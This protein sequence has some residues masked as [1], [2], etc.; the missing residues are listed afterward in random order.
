MKKTALLTLLLNSFLSCSDKTHTSALSCFFKSEEQ[1]D[2]LLKAPLEIEDEI[3]VEDKQKLQAISNLKKINVLIEKMN[4][5]QLEQTAN[6]HTLRTEKATLTKEQLDV[7]LARH[8]KIK[9]KIFRIKKELHL[10]EICM[11]NSTET[12]YSE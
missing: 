10:L 6:F 5:I 11:I 8:K 2:V 1:A 7:L 4:G 12:D 9:R 3:P